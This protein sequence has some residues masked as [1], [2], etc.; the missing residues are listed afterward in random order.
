M[1]LDTLWK[2]NLLWPRVAFAIYLGLTPRFDQR[3][4]CH[5]IQCR[6]HCA[7]LIAFVR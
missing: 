6:P 5:A 1:V 3:D 7:C 2:E 4:Q